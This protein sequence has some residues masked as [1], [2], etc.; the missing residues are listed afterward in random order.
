MLSVSQLHG[1]LSLSL[2]DANMAMVNSLVENPF[3]ERL[4][5]LLHWE[6]W[7]WRSSPRILLPAQDGVRWTPLEGTS[8][9]FTVLLQGNKKGV[10]QHRAEAAS[11]VLLLLSLQQGLYSPCLSPI[12]PPVTS[13]VGPSAWSVLERWHNCNDLFPS[14]LHKSCLSQQN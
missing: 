5:C 13:T 7:D 12:A 8:L 6:G 3:R 10:V 9:N 2:A 4:V 1:D 11:P 14:P